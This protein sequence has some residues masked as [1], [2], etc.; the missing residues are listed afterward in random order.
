MSH[1]DPHGPPDRTPI[2]VGEVWENPVT[3]ERAT[4]LERPWDNP[5]GRGTAELKP[6]QPQRLTTEEAAERART[7][8]TLYERAL[9]G[10][11]AAPHASSASGGKQ[12]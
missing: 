12:R 3:R 1:P 6:P 10:S 7:Y 9:G 11:H 2:R 5:A 8:K 4:I